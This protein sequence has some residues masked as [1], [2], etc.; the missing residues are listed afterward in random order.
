ME[1]EQQASDLDQAWSNFDPDKPLGFGSCFLVQQ[2]IN[3]M[4]RLKRVLERKPAPS[5]KY[6][7]AGF[8]GAGKSTQLRQ[9]V[10]NA[11]LLNKYFIVC[12][13][14]RETSDERNISYVDLLLA[15]GNQ[16]LKV[17]N[18]NGIKLDDS[19]YEEIQNWGN[20]VEER[21]K[22]R[23][24]EAGAIVE[25]GTGAGVDWVLKFFGKLTAKVKSEYSSRTV[26]R[27]VLEPQL[28]DLLEKIDLIANGIR[29]KTQKEVLLLVDDTD[30]PLFEQASKLFREHLSPLLQPKLIIV[31]TVP[32]WVHF[33]NDFPEIRQPHAFLLPNIKLNKQDDPERG[34]DPDGWEIMKEFIDKRMQLSLIDENA[35]IEAIVMSGGVFREEA[36]I[37]Q[38]A[39]DHALEQ[40]K[41]KV[42]LENVRKAINDLQQDYRRLITALSQKDLDTLYKIRETRK[43]TPGENVSNLLNNL[44]VLEYVNSVNWPDV[45]PLLR[46]ILEQ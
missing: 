6:F 26:I 15:M 1:M 25:A 2:E 46:D 22:Q 37:M 43:Y 11:S 45:N 7:L 8:K 38:M 21:I 29:T 30:K 10:G 4:G 35:L 31:Y 27:E 3:P 20:K 34:I 42:E 12:F 16:L 17:C 33:S 13:S 9:L 19:I 41:Q 28:T 14:I 24:N 18:E 32:V 44:L 23:Q 39:I 36:R 5:Q 40:D